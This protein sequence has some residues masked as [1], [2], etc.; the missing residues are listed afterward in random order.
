MLRIT[1]TETG[2]EE[3]WLLQ[4]RMTKNSVAELVTSWKA[5]LPGL[6]RVVDLDGVTSIDRTGEQVLS[7]M[8]H[9]GA[10][11]VASGVYTKHLLEQLQ[12]AEG[13]EKLLD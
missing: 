11:F 13:N 5:P 8:V 6:R 3:T 1:V 7:M 10:R 9:D 4:G 2:L 12:A